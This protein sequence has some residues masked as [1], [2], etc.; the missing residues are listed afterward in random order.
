MR[1]A[2]AQRSPKSTPGV[3]PFVSFTAA[4]TAD[5]VSI[6]YNAIITPIHSGSQNSCVNGKRNS[7][8]F[9]QQKEVNSVVKAN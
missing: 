3:L 2:H 5:A 1:T 8:T 4:A 9:V 7:S 6:K